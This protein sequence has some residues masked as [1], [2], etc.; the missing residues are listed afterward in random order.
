MLRELRDGI[1]LFQVRT[2]RQ[3]EGTSFVEAESKVRA[4]ESGNPKKWGLSLWGGEGRYLTTVTPCG[5]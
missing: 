1:P 4:L 2:A 5:V 3:N